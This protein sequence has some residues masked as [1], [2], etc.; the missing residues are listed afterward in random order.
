[1]EAFFTVLSKLAI[2]AVLIAV[3]FAVTKLKKFSEK[4]ISEMTWLLMNIVTPCVIIDSFLNLDSGTLEVSELLLS[5]GLAF[6]SLGIGIALTPLLFRKEAPIQK[7]GYRF[8]MTFNNAGFMGIP[9]VQSILG[10]EAVIYAS[11]F[12]AVFNFVLWTFGYRL[13]ASGEKFRPIKIFLNAGTIGFTTGVVIYLLNFDLPEIIS[14]PINSMAALNTPIAMIIFGFFLAKIDV[15]EILTDKKIYY[16]SFLRLIAIPSILI[17]FMSIIRPPETMFMSTA[18]QACTPTA[19]A[20]VLFTAMF[21]ADVKL[22]SKIVTATNLLS[23][24]T[25]PLFV[26]LVQILVDSIL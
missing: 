19:T 16:V 2:M 21:K 26:S 20:T 5:T 1:M 7:K 25:I 8:A 15:K 24:I 22:A 18:I 14:S 17:L 10:N 12:V 6:L 13:M 23:L 11:I 3:G 9:L 4:T